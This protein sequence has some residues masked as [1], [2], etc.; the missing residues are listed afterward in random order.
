MSEFKAPR[1]G[2]RGNDRKDWLLEL[3][4]SAIPHRDVLINV[5]HHLWTATL[6]GNQA[7]IVKRMF[8][9]M[10]QPVIGDLVMEYGAPFM[11]GEDRLNALGIL[12]EHRTE[13]VHTEAVWERIGAEYI[14]LNE[15][16][17]TEEAWYV[18]YGNAAVDICRWANCDFV[19]VPAQFK[20]FMED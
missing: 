20:Q 18:Q 14:E 11:T 19:A 12:V 6:V 4:T 9:R 2:V 5:T 13:W 8:E 17:P 7:P 15:V 16:R 1:E 3:D 10:R